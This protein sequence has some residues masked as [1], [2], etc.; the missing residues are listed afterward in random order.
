MG[1]FF[2]LCWGALFFLFPFLS[3]SQ[4][5]EGLQWV[6]IREVS[7]SGRSMVLG[8]GEGS[9]VEKGM[10]GSFFREGRFLGEARVVEVRRGTSFWHFG[11]EGFPPEVGGLKKGTFLEM[12]SWQSALRG[13]VAP[14][15]KR[16][17]LVLLAQEKQ[18]SQGGGDE[19]D[20]L[21]GGLEGNREWEEGLFESSIVKRY[22]GGEDGFV[23]VSEEEP[24]GYIVDLEKWTQEG[25]NVFYPTPVRAGEKTKQVVQSIWEGKYREV[26]VHLSKRKALRYDGEDVNEGQ[27]SGENDNPKGD[28]KGRSSSPAVSGFSA[29]EGSGH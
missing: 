10:R 2:L 5:G 9:G 24:H 25:E 29:G 14:R 4:L 19:G 8:R 11:E 3:M 6:R 28:G 27:Q 13:R 23:V 15:V 20:F 12:L 18:E 16:R 7:T 1:V 22:R 17:R 26:V 21:Q